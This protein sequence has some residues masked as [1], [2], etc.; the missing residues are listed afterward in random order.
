LE[1]LWSTLRPLILLAR[2]PSFR[3]ADVYLACWRT[4]LPKLTPSSVSATVLA[5]VVL[6]T[7][8][9]CTCIWCGFPKHVSGP[10][11]LDPA[12]EP[13]ISSV[14]WTHA[15]SCS[16]G[17]S[18]PVIIKTTVTK[19]TSRHLTY[20]GSVSDCSGTISSAS[21]TINCPQQP[22][23]YSGT[24]TV[25]DP[26]GHSDTVHFSFGPCQDGQETY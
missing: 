7:N 3:L 9:G 18:S 5:L 10:Y 21:S 24:V 6:I 8:S 22:G 13:E 4:A 20:A 17:V 14:T 16:T 12:P 15:P 25:T 26:N 23:I 2:L 1:R 11:N 19:D